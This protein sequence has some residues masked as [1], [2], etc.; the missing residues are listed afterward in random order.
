MYLPGNQK[1]TQGVN[2][3]LP[4]YVMEMMMKKFLKS[5]TVLA[6]ILV[7]VVLGTILA[8]PWMDRWGSTDD[9]I[10]SNYLGDK[11]VPEPARTEIANSHFCHTSLLLFTANDQ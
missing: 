5:I 4:C 10:A 7:I 11:L 6:G 3:P 8:T 2:N 1:K 9:E